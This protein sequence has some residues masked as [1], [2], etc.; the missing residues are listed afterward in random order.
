MLVASLGLGLWL[1]PFLVDWR[2]LWDQRASQVN[3]Q[4]FKAIGREV[5]LD[6]QIRLEL[7]P[8]AKLHLSKLRLSNPTGTSQPDMLQIAGLELELEP[9]PLLTGHLAVKHLRLIRPHLILETTKE[10][11]G[12]WLFS[13]PKGAVPELAPTPISD[14]F[15]E[16]PLWVQQFELVNGRV[17]YLAADRAK[18]EVVDAINANVEMESLFGPLRFRGDLRKDGQNFSARF[19]T[20]LLS[21]EGPVAITAQGHTTDGAWRFALGGLIIEPTKVP[22]YDGHFLLESNAQFWTLTG[23]LVAAAERVEL[24]KAE[25]KWKNLTARGELGVR[26]GAEP[27]LTGQFFLASVDL[28]KI[29][30][31]KKVTE[32]AISATSP[33][34][35]NTDGLSQSIPLSLPKKAKKEEAPPHQDLWPL[36][37]H[38]KSRLGLDAK[39]LLWQGQAVTDFSIRL[40]QE[41][42]QLHL[43][44]LGLTLPGG[45]RFEGSGPVD[46]S[47]QNYH[48]EWD[49]QLTGAQA[50]PLFALAGISLPEQPADRWG[51]FELS[52]KLRIRPDQWEMTQLSGQ[53][54]QTKIEGS[55][56]WTRVGEQSLNVGLI[57]DGLDLDLYWPMPNL[58]A[59]KV[60]QDPRTPKATP[61]APPT[62]VVTSQGPTLAKANDASKPSIQVS[63]EIWRQLEVNFDLEAKNMILAG[64]KADSTWLKLNWHDNR[65]GIQDF[66]LDGWS[67]GK[68]EI[69]G[70]IDQALDQP[71]FDLAGH[72]AIKNLELLEGREQFKNFEGIFE[73]E[74][75]IDQLSMSVDVIAEGAKVSANMVGDFSDPK[76]VLSGEVNGIIPSWQLVPTLMGY[77]VSD[78]KKGPLELDLNFNRQEQ[79]IS[80]EAQAKIMATAIKAEGLVHDN[81][82]EKMTLAIDDHSAILPFLL[83]DPSAVLKLRSQVSGQSQDWQ[84]NPLELE[85]G[86][87]R[88]SGHVGLQQQP[89]RPLLQGELA[90]NKI[91]AGNMGQGQTPN[92]AKVNNSVKTLN[93]TGTAAA[94]PTKW[95]ISSKPLDWS[96]LSQLDMDLAFLVDQL[97]WQGWQWQKAQGNLRL[98]A[99]LLTGTLS[100]SQFYGGTFTGRLEASAQPLP[101]VLA[102]IKVEGAQAQPIFYHLLGRK[103]ISGNLQLA[104][105]LGAKGLSIQSMVSLADGDFSFSIKDG[106]LTGVSLAEV[107]QSFQTLNVAGNPAALVQV[108][109]DSAKVEKSTTIKNWQGTLNLRSGIVRSNNLKGELD[110]G[111]V[112]SELALHLLAQTLDLR[113]RISLAIPNP[114]QI[115]VDVTGPWQN[116]NYRPR[117]ENV[118]LKLKLP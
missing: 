98:E 112:Y 116:L 3:A 69:Q 13:P 95:V 37:K 11:R 76:G 107:A 74:G 48:A 86:D 71:I 108:F 68:I 85:R 79:Q 94:N 72:V 15:R 73:F 60:E 92:S 36:P 96:A 23:Q 30:K 21:R 81:R 84:F 41:K 102:D 105:R 27:E 67:G 6:G 90:I 7:L 31:T 33:L 101:Q 70:G 12:N 32:S 22:R 113:N 45:G 39:I 111:E 93:T 43:D 8:K 25:L 38:W 115:H 57:L 65:F 19:D 29:E 103:E 44:G 117:M 54:D 10:G 2:F 87:F 109:E 62:S 24:Q 28:D 82:I 77:R 64:Q 46:I 97:E 49:W 20:G 66:G 47:G 100:N 34:T 50:R 5:H 9:W 75:P 56:F 51:H 78:W 16:L 17:S 35:Q 52:G 118:R 14:E 80:F 58:V 83:G 106:S 42:D 91:T 55:M 59:V 53:L 99:G 104:G 18:P 40:R 4:L 26:L 89:I 110:G 61:L 63:P 1:G 88:L 114:P